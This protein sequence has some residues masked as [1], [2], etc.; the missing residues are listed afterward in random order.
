MKMNV[1][2]WGIYLFLDLCSGRITNSVTHFNLSHVSGTS[3]SDL[4]APSGSGFQVISGGSPL[5]SFNHSVESSERGESSLTK[6]VSHVNKNLFSTVAWNLVSIDGSFTTS[7]SRNIVGEKVDTLSLGK[8]ST[9]H[10][11]CVVSSNGSN[12]SWCTGL[13]KVESVTDGLDS[14]AVNIL[15]WSESFTLFDERHIR[16]AASKVLE[17]LHSLWHLKVVFPDEL[18]KHW[19]LVWV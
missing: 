6:I 12:L 13:L 11:T 4:S 1:N 8:A 17:R 10:K 15:A 7:S 18:Q 5:P 3:V 19:A 9:V 2:L 14:N 16:L